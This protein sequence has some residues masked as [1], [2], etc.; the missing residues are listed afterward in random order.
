MAISKE[1]KEN[2]KKSELKRFD[3]IEDFF[4]RKYGSD[5][6][7]TYKEEYKTIKL[8]EDTIKQNSRQ[9][10]L[11]EPTI[12]PNK[13]RNRPLAIGI[14]Q[15]DLCYSLNGKRYGEPF[16]VGKDMEGFFQ[17]F[18]NREIIIRTLKR[19]YTTGG[20]I[21][22]GDLEFKKIREDPALGIKD[23]TSGKVIC[24][25]ANGVW[26]KGKYYKN[27]I[28]GNLDNTETL[29]NTKVINRMSKLFSA[30]PPILENFLELYLEKSKRPN[31]TS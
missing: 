21:A 22:N 16:E 25:L 7:E 4:N 13:S 19:A 18:Y 20:D 12:K 30:T 9:Y 15:G 1:Q 24:Y 6:L 29:K 26:K 31:Q 27:L 5:Y 23:I 17:N 11:L 2:W 14:L 8:F 28:N 10:F 3:N